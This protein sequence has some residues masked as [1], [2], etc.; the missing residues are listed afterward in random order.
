MALNDAAKCKLMRPRCL[1]LDVGRWAVPGAWGEMIADPSTASDAKAMRIYHGVQ[2]LIL[3]LDDNGTLQSA[4]DGR[5]RCPMCT[6]VAGM[7]VRPTNVNVTGL[8]PQPSPASLTV[9]PSGA[10]H[11]RL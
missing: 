5:P 6:D 11:I 2:E 1:Q 7:D 9:S 8:Q 10:Y 3:A 4:P